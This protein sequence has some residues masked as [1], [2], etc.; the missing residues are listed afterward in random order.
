[1]SFR[2]KPESPSDDSPVKDSRFRGND[3]LER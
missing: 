1:M 2:R 3:L